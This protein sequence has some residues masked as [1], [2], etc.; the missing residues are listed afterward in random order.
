MIIRFAPGRTLLLPILAITP[1]IMTI[2]L[3]LLDATWIRCPTTFAKTIGTTGALLGLGIGLF[4]VEGVG[5]GAGVRVGVGIGLGLVIATFT[6][7][8]VEFA[9]Q[10]PVAS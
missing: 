1:L 9:S 10:Y 8:V 4:V 5:F 6:V 3:E 2:T 7:K